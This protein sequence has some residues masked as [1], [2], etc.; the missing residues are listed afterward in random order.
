MRL[1]QPCVL[2]A[3]ATVVEA[4]VPNTIFRDGQRLWSHI[5]G[6]QT[7]CVLYPFVDACMDAP[8]V[9]SHCETQFPYL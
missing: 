1:R 2:T 7:P 9:C 8:L 6:S 4:R 3:L 5:S